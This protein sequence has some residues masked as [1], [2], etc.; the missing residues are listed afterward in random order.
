MG[1]GLGLAIAKSI[2][3]QFHGSVSLSNR[4]NGIGLVFSYSQRQSKT[5][6]NG[7]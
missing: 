4:I 6:L 5:S 3:D 2:A 7:N 1:S